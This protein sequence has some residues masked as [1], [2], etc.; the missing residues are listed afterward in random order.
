MTDARLLV[1]AFALS[2][3]AAVLFPPLFDHLRRRRA[4]PGLTPEQARVFEAA[5]EAAA[6]YSANGASIGPRRFRVGFSVT[7]KEVSPR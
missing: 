1:L 4:G 7:E 6:F 5:R 3:P 2:F